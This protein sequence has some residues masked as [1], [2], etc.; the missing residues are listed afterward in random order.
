MSHTTRA[1]GGTVFIHNGD[2]SGDTVIVNGGEVTVPYDDIAFLVASQ[3]ADATEDGPQINVL[4]DDQRLDLVK[5]MIKSELVRHQSTLDN[6][7]S[8][9]L[10]VL[11]RTVS[12]PDNLLSALRSTAVAVARSEVILTLEDIL[13]ALE[14]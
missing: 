1:P 11:Q 5:R 3:K 13:K 8:N 12:H 9:A 2:Y 14:G 7:K 4:T 6:A 10:D